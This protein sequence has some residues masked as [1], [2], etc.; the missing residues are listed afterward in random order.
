[1]VFIYLRVY[2]VSHMLQDVVHNCYIVA[3]VSQYAGDYFVFHSFILLAC[4][5]F[6]DS[7]PFSGA[8]SVPLY[9]V[10]FLATLLHQLFF[11]PLSPRL[12]IYFLAY[13]YWRLFCR[14]YKQYTG[15]F[16]IKELLSH[17]H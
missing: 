17:N 10:L 7:L 8:S 9:H 1:M 14:L 5:E 15:I 11:H 16:S 6:D 4:A 2:H 13:L 3:N 12:A